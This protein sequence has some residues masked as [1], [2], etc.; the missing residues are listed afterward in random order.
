MGE[1]RERLQDWVNR[2]VGGSEILYERD[3]R[4]KHPV[5]SA[6][7]LFVNSYVMLFNTSS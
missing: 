6:G 4:G 2:D 3:R 1:R 5:L 7:T